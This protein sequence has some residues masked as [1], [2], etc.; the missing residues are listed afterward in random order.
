[1]YMM[2]IIPDQVRT[3]AEGPAV[4]VGTRGVNQ[5]SAGPKEF[6][7]VQDSGSGVTGAGYVA[8]VA[9]TYS[10]VMA[11]T[12]TSAPAAGQGKLVGVAQA[13]IAAN[14][15]GWLQV[16]G[17]CAAIRV[18]ASAAAYTTLNTT[19]TAGQIDDDATAGAEVIEGLVLNAANGGAAG[20]VAGMLT[21]P[22]V[23]RTL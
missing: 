9:S 17:A 6:V 2:G 15:Y 4:A 22:V 16:Y 21:Y 12:T 19:G 14:G 20:T 1:M 10:A 8:L 5:T 3:S 11:S 13:A 7:Y 23:G 18:A